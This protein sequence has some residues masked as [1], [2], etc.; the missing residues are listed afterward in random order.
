MDGPSILFLGGSALVIIYLLVHAVLDHRKWKEEKKGCEKAFR[1][2]IEEWLANPCEATAF[3]MQALL[4]RNIDEWGLD[5][6]C[7][8][9]R[10][11][12]RKRLN[13]E[14]YKKDCKGRCEGGCEGGCEEEAGEVG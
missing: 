8:V 1:E 3:R 13:R 2:A 10:E 12:T 4:D 9:C 7:S 5:N 11:I 14:S 6:N